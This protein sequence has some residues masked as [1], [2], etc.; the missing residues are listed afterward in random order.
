MTGHRRQHQVELLAQQQRVPGLRK[1][2]GDVGDQLDRI[3]LAQR[4]RYRPH[5]HRAGPE[6]LQHQPQFRQLARRFLK[7][8]A[9]NL[10]EFHN[11]R[12]QQRLRGRSPL[13]RAT[14][15]QPLQHQPLMR[16]VLVDDHQPILGFRDD[17]GVRHLPPRHAQ[18]MLRRSHNRFRRHFGTRR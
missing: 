6:P 14:C 18:R 10:L 12:H 7:P 9:G 8:V 5:Q 15:P 17:I 2:V 3:A 4:C 1:V 11:L 16:R 13:P